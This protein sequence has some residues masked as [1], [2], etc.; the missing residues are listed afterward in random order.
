MTKSRFDD[1]A[2]AA[3]IYKEVQQIC[4]DV[5]KVRAFR[6]RPSRASRILWPSTGKAPAVDPDGIICALVAKAATTHTAIKHLT[7]AGLAPDA[8]ALLRVLVENAVLVAWL[9]NDSV[10]RLDL[11]C[12]SMRLHIRHSKELTETFY[13]DEDVA[14]VARELHKEGAAIAE[15]FGDTQY[16]WARVIDP[17]TGRL[18]QVKFDDMCKEVAPDGFMS[19][20]VVFR[21]GQFVHS[22]IPSLVSFYNRHALDRIFFV[23]AEPDDAHAGEALTMANLMMYHAL[24]AL[25]QYA[26]LELDDKIAAVLLAIQNQGLP[27]PD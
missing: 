17:E 24:S 13:P 14:T 1:Y 7:D 19:D 25:N 8:L 2:T 20:V 9:L 5:S 10:F 26:A 6:R 12:L 22:E 11:Y 16:R 4:V 18:K 3:S 21:L 23:A 15:V 27:L